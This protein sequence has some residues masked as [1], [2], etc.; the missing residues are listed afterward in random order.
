MNNL[1]VILGKTSSGKDRTVNE[2]ISKY[3]YKKIITYTTRPMRKAEKQDITYHF[4]N[5]DE[6]I[7]KI[8]TGFFA[9]W[10]SYVTVNGLWYYGTALEDL[11]NADD[12]SVIILTPAG[13][14]D[15]IKKM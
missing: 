5:T 11:E 2:L 4:I 1:L 14:R 12:N 7:N 6:F 10:K 8:N 3:N 15:I 9:E 13:Y